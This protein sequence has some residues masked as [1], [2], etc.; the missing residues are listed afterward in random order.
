MK[1]KILQLATSTRYV[2]SGY[3]MSSQEC[4]QFEELI[5]MP[6]EFNATHDTT[7]QALAE[8]EKFKDKLQYCKLA[9]IPFIHLR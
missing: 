6:W 4:Y 3:D 8:I 9:I 1:Y 5:D 7:E 2:P